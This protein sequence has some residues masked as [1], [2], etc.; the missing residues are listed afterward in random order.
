MRT[1]GIGTIAFALAWIISF[2]AIETAS[3]N[4]GHET[5]DLLECQSWEYVLE[6]N[7]QLYLC[8]TNI[9]ELEHATSAD[10]LGTAGVFLVI[11][12]NGSPIKVANIPR[13]GYGLAG[14]YFSGT[15]LFAPTFATDTVDAYIT[16]N[17]SF[18]TT[19][20][21][22]THINITFNEATSPLDTQDLLTLE[23]PRMIFRLEFSDP[24][25]PLET[26]IRGGGITD[27][28][29]VYT[30]EAFEVLEVLIPEAFNVPLENVIPTI[31]A[32]PDVPAFL[33]AIQDAGRETYFAQS[34][35]SWGTLIG[36]KSYTMTTFLIN[37]VMI[38][39]LLGL[40]RAIEVKLGWRVNYKA[41]YFSL[42]P[43]LLIDAY[44]GA[45]GFDVFIIFIDM[46][47]IFGAG[48]FANRHIP[49]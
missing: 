3:A 12:E 47:F 29:R 33:Q 25:I 42:F 34:M 5:L 35:R 19:P 43:T 14:V 38:G 48:M 13:V 24:D 31:D 2:L 46:V 15:D 44:I 6:Q 45:I 28:G 11:E 8:R 16:Q 32:D 21:E 40:M 9:V 10:D 22:S 36:I 17:P 37:F 27:E 23:L 1:A 41:V 26:L 39:A 49:S 4:H 30:N 18:F 20:D 7:D